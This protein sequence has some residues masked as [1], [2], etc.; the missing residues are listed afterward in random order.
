MAIVTVVAGMVLFTASKDRIVPKINLSPYYKKQSSFSV[1]L[2]AARV[3]SY[4]RTVHAE[5]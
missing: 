3:Y 2:I 4:E 1:L 5:W